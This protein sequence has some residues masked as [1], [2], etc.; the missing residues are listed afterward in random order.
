M[1]NKISVVIPMYNEEENVEKIVSAIDIRLA[2]ICDYELILIDDGSTDRTLTEI[3][4]V[5]ERR[6]R[7][8]YL[9]LSRNFGHQNA[10]R[11]GF[12]L[13]T[14]D[15]V[16]SMDGDMQHPPELLPEMIEHWRAGYK[17]V[18]TV[19]EETNDVSW[20]KRLSSELFYRMVNR[21]SGIGLQ[22]GSAD[23]RLLDRKV[24]DVVKRLDERAIFYRGIISWVG[25]QQCRIS[26]VPHKRIHG[27]SKYSI[28][29]MFLLAV[30]GMTA[31]SFLPLRLAAV[32][33]AFIALLSFLYV[34]Y[35]FLIKL[36]THQAIS[37]WL[38]VM[39][40]VY[41]LGGI[42][43]IFIGLCGE[44]IGRIFM[45]VKGRPHYIVSESKVPEGVS[46]RV[47]IG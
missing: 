19:R 9:S 28:R 40:G 39:A 16:I 23:F 11:A 43:L 7:V 6:A 15:A 31:F 22:P 38:S 17:V 26:Y 47:E 5:V 45:E 10:L 24:V 14:G 41:L 27:K 33:G 44:Y 32:T 3:K 35:A 18:F 20:F 13:A 12:D 36:F 29:K 37:G 42:Q 34:F 21:V 4:R 1:K 46:S 30:D 8:F 2:D 25:F